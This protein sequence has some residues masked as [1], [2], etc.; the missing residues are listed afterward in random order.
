MSILAATFDTRRL[1]GS[2]T[3]RCAGGMCGGDGGLVVPLRVQTMAITLPALE[4][5]KIGTGWSGSWDAATFADYYGPGFNWTES[6]SGW[7]DLMIDNRMPPDS[8]YIN[9]P[10]PLARWLHKSAHPMAA[11]AASKRRRGL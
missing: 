2:V 10:R 7:F 1:E 4:E 5:S 8:I 6:K 11:A 9:K 3:V